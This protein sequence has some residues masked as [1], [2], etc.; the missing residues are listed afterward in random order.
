MD[1]ED[2]KIWNRTSLCA[3]SHLRISN[4]NSP[5]H[6]CKLYYYIKKKLLELLQKESWHLIPTLSTADQTHVECEIEMYLCNTHTPSVSFKSAVCTIN[7]LHMLY[8]EEHFCFN[9]V[10]YKI[11]Q[12]SVEQISLWFFSS[13]VWHEEKRSK[14]YFA[15]VY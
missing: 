2:I 1:K 10:I 4:N 9:L 13:E 7:H 8:S 6:Y 12:V 15:F 3:V 14:I 5:F 11:N